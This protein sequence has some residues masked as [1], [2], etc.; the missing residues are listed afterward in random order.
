MDK[1]IY[2]IGIGMGSLSDLTE[3]AKKL[4]EEAELI[5]GATR[6]IKEIQS[7]HNG[8]PEFIFEYLPIKIVGQIQQSKKKQIVVAMSGD[9]GFYSG[10]KKLLIELKEAGIPAQVEPGISSLSYFASRLKMS[11]EDIKIVNL[12]GCT[13]NLSAA[14]RKHEKVFAVTQGQTEEICKELTEAGFGSISLYV[15][16]KLSYPEEEIIK[17]TPAE[18]KEKEKEPLSV[19]L[20]IGKKEERFVTAGIPDHA[21]IRGNIPMTKS[22]IRAIILSKLA[23]RETDVIYDIGAGTGSVSIELAIAACRG[24][25]YAIEYQPEALTLIQE[26]KKRF[27]CN[28]LEIISGMAPEAIEGL[29]LADIVFIGGTKGNL[30]SILQKIIHQNHSIRI[31][32]S[33]VTIE[34]ISEV[35]VNLEQLGIQVID[36]SQVAVTKLEKVGNYHM[37]KAQNP[38]F[39]VIGQYSYPDKTRERK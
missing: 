25:V 22:E 14:L 31:A 24:K 9:S 32:I 29:P 4:L 8:L 10:T 20:L 11:W 12:H 6:I 5:I 37:M 36:A 16:K 28:N 1:E 18:Y 30:L 27:G 19:I 23:V 17:T 39:L 26:N 21:F 33:A 34:T 15:G 2:I 7:W 13:E 38:V 35:F 3:R